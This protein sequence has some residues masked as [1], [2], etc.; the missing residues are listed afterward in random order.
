MEELGGVSIWSYSSLVLLLDL[1]PVTGRVHYLDRGHVLDPSTSL[2]AWSPPLHRR[3]SCR[4]KNS[5]KSL[6]GSVRGL[7][8]YFH[9]F[10]YVCAAVD[11]R[12]SHSPLPSGFL[13]VH[14]PN[15]LTAVAHAVPD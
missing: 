15:P 8:G 14:S 1:L 13:H 3:L 4:A 6:M 7:G 9:H 10:S 2:Q 12:P 11:P 5:T